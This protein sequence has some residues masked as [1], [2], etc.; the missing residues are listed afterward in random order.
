[1]FY[2]HPDLTLKRDTFQ[3]S[4]AIDLLV[5]GYTLIPPSDTSREPDGGG[6][7]T[8]L[9]GRSPL[10]IP[11]VELDEPPKDL[12]DW[13][14]SLSAP[15]QPR[16]PQT[17]STPNW[18]TGP[19]PEGH[20]NESLTKIAGY[21]HRKLDDDSLVRHLVHQANQTQCRPPLSTSEV[22]RILDSI[23]ARDGASHFR[24]VWPAK[25]EVIR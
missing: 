8:W 18:L 3:R 6:P 19:I 25:L 2:Y 11:L 5:N 15:K 14:Q 24:G 7:Y 16:S 12:L 21:Y 10:E 4:S 1:V 22:D 20:R 23:L 13:W 17:Y 9:P